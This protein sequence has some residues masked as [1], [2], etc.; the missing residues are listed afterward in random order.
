MG[1]TQ[2]QSATRLPSLPPVTQ[3][4]PPL[5]CADMFSFSDLKQALAKYTYTGYV[6]LLS[7]YLCG[8]PYLDSTPSEVLVKKLFVMVENVSKDRMSYITLVVE[9]FFLAAL[10]L[11]FRKINTNR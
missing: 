10:V 8:Y 7:L 4:V 11:D 2:K 5:P 3:W 9:D 6:P 1:E